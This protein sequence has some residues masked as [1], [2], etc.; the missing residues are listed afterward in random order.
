MKKFGNAGTVM[1]RYARGSPAPC[2]RSGRPP[3]GI[4]V[5]RGDRLP[6]VGA[7]GELPGDVVEA[8]LLADRVGPGAGPVEVPAPQAFLQHALQ[9]EAFPPAPPRLGERR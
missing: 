7:V 1:R 5:P 2:S 3:R 9:P 6:Q 8:E 4:G